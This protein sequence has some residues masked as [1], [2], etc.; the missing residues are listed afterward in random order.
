MTEWLTDEQ[1][2]SI[3]DEM[4]AVELLSYGLSQ[5]FINLIDKL[6]DQAKEANRLRIAKD[7]AY[8]ERNKCVIG[9]M[10]LARDLGY[11]VGWAKHPEEDTEW[12]DDWRNIAVIELP[13][14]QLTWHF[15]DSERWMLYSFEPL[16]DHQWDGHSTEEKYR[17]LFDY[18]PWQ[19][20]E[21]APKD[22]TNILVYLKSSIYGTSWQAVAHWA[23]ISSDQQGIY[24]WASILGDGKGRVDS[25]T[26]TPTHWK[27]LSEPPKEEH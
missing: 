13:T 8:A 23:D 22:G 6:A 12:E 2:N 4:A 21:S 9:L 1:L 10:L 24:E 20:I 26:S 3:Q 5:Y 15:H 18:T 14:G 11:K 25:C 17:R 7:N 16:K 27:P 19:D